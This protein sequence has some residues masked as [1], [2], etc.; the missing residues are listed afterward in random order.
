[1]TDNDDIDTL[2]SKMLITCKD[3]D[4]YMMRLYLMSSNRAINIIIFDESEQE[5]RHLMHQN[6]ASF[7]M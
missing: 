6:A 3:R 2:T 4:R 1:M 7:S 5:I